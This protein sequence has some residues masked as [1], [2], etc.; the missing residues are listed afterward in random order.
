MDAGLVI[1]VVVVAV[2]IASA[3]VYAGIG[4]S[5]AQWRTRASAPLS[6]TER[7]GDLREEVRSLVIAS[8]ERRVRRGEEPLD[9]DAEVERRLRDA[10]RPA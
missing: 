10:D 6:G 5:L 1:A 4:R 3:L 2:T 7:E 9:V 8:N